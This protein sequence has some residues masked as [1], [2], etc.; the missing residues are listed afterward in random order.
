MMNPVL[1]TEGLEKY[2]QLLKS[3][4]LGTKAKKS[5]GV[6]YIEGTGDTA[7]VWL[8]SHGD[9]TEY[10]PGL[11]IAYKP[12]IA[13]ASDLTLNINGLGA[14]SVI[15]N[16]NS[17]VTTHYGVESVI[18]L[19]YTIDASG[20]AYWKVADYD[21][22]TKT[23]SSNK[24]GSKMYII[25]ATSQSTSGQTTYSN[26]NCYI[27]TDNCLYSGGK[28]V[29]DVEGTAA[30][31]TKADSATTATSA[32]KATQDGSGTVIT[33]TYATKSE[34]TSVS[35]TA[36]NAASVASTAKATAD[37]AVK[38]VNGVAPDSNGN[39]TIQTGGDTSNLVP[40]TG[41][42][43]VLA[44]FNAVGSFDGSNGSFEVL[45]NQDSPD[46]MII[47]NQSD[48]SIVGCKVTFS[49]SG[50]RGAFVKN[51]FLVG[52]PSLFT[53]EFEGNVFPETFF[54]D[55]VMDLAVGQINIV[56]FANYTDN[57]GDGMGFVTVKRVFD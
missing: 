24:T 15:R 39:V 33:S 5:A 43:G 30:S 55:Y 13:G 47:S 41:D 42:R 3:K 44:G 51:I 7:G 8:G 40:K 4:E 11:M 23:R 57:T 19:V 31:A 34:L 37:A 29:L 21:S 56:I 22:D 26:S 14:V 38:K 52:E 18:F 45:I 35:T 16:V 12:S 50:A 46:D 6:F 53:F 49:N 10:Y 25:G 28:K 2:H 1:D 36:N 48:E 32:T 9:I 27:G 20:T 54:S 17:A